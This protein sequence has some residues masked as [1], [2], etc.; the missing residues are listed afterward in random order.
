[1]LKQTE[2]AEKKKNSQHSEKQRIRGAIAKTAK[3]DDLDLSAMGVST[4]VVVSHKE[5]C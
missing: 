3:E 5:R 2:E 1:M 4:G